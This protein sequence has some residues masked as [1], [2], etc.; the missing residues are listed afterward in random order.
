METVC[1]CCGE[2]IKSPDELR[3]IALERPGI[4]DGRAAGLI[5]LGRALV[6]QLHISAL[7]FA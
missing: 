4:F 6:H 2:N 3:S 1:L 7:L 5:L